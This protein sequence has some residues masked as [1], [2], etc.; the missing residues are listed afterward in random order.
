MEENGVWR[1]VGGRRIFIKEGQDLASAMKES[2]K[3]SK[4]SKVQKIEKIKYN[5]P[6]DNSEFTKTI[7]ENI[8]KLIEEYNSPLEEVSY[9]S[10]KQ[11]FKTGEAGSITNYGKNLSIGQSTQEN[12]YHEFAHTLMDEQ[13]YK[14]LDEKPEFWNKI[15]KVEK[16]YYK[17]IRQ[18]DKKSI[19]S[20]KEYDTNFNRLD[21]INKI[22]ISPSNRYYETST[23]E[24]FAESFAN[25][26]L[27]MTKSKYAKQIVDLIDEEFKKK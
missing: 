20:F 22:R 21:A 7:K 13:R 23:D 3:F 18:I 4:S 17:E 11:T 2:G 16:D 19:S 6:K 26:K 24:F 5:L 10:A 15:K 1:T 14:L 9:K 27:G 12:I 25:Y 8:D